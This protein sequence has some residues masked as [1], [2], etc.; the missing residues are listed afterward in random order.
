MAGSQMREDARF[1]GVSIH[2]SAY[3]D[4]PVSLGPGTKIWHFAHVLGHVTIG[5]NCSIGQNVMIGPRV[6]IGSGVRIQNNVSLYEGVTLDDDVFCGPSCVFTN[7]NNPRSFISRKDEFHKTRV[8][9]GASIGANAT[10]VCG[11]D[12]G[13]FAFIGAGAVVTKDVSAFA[14]MVGAPA[15]RVGWMSRAGEKLGPD[16]TCPRDGSRYRLVDEDTLEAIDP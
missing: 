3:V 9:R 4:D 6:D 10:I 1:P 8:G 12:I 14:L 7:V 11:H 5:E 13:P 16:L 2:E 15:R